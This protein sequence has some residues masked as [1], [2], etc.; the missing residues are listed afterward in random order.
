MKAFVVMCDDFLLGRKKTK[1]Q[2]S[3]GK[4]S[5]ALRSTVPASALILP[6]T[7]GSAGCM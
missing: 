5:W 3:K 4:L 2:N 1:K 6:E 7:S